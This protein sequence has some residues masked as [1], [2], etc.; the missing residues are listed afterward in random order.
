MVRHI[1]SGSAKAP[2]YV[3]QDRFDADARADAEKH[4]HAL[5]FREVRSLCFSL[6][7]DSV[8]AGFH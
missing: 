8:L 3:Q 1:E 4:Q 6:C 2:E 7:D 5:A